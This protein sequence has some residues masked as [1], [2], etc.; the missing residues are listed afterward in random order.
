M[1][2][3][4]EIRKSFASDSA[5]YAGGLQLRQI[6]GNDAE[7]LDSAIV[8]PKYAKPTA[9]TV[10]TTTA[11]DISTKPAGA[12]DI[13]NR[14]HVWV[15]AEFTGSAGSITIALQMYDTANAFLGMSQPVTLQAQG[16]LR[17]GAAGPYIASG[18]VLDVGPAATVYP[19]V[20]AINDTSV[21][22]FVS[23]L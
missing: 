12:I 6:G 5:T 2:I 4:D 21:N 23:R 20:L 18:A 13:G 7:A 19:A 15:D 3:G 1:A 22:L 11:A 9:I 10:T 8:N 14:P 16:V 17:N